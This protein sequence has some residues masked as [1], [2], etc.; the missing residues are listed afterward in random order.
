MPLPTDLSVEHV[1]PLTHSLVSGLKNHLNEVVA[2]VSYNAR[3]QNRF[4]P[5]R[6]KDH[7]PPLTFGDTAEFLVENRWVVCEFGGDVWW[8]ESS[9]LGCGANTGNDWERTEFHRNVMR[10]VQAAHFNDSRCV[11]GRL[12]GAK[13][14]A[15][16][17]QKEAAR[18]SGLKNRGKKHQKW[19]CLVTGHITTA[20]R[21]NRWQRSRGIDE[22]QREKVE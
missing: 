15:S 2:T 3:K 21:M 9:R 17:K 12:R 5:Y 7:H 18:Q 14:P 4:V 8:A 1:D 20:G 13:A 16:E 10:E 22:T 11:A 19:R 6:V